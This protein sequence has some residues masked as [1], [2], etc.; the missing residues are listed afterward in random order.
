MKKNE[1]LEFLQQVDGLLTELKEAEELRE[2]FLSMPD[3]LQYEVELT[4]LDEKIQSLQAQKVTLISKAERILQPLRRY[5]FA[6]IASR[7]HFLEG[8]TWEQI[9][10]KL[11]FNAAET[12]KSRVYRALKQ[13]SDEGLIDE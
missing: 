7:L 5:S 8:L 3:G 1:A 2:T 12:V 6:Y 9:A 4:F 13:V 11:G 10:D